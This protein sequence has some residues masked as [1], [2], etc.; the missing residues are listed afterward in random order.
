MI[1]ATV[2]HYR[3]IE[4][5]GGGGMGVVYKAEDTR[6]GRGVALK[7][8][9]E[10]F[11]PDPSA[12]ERFLREARAASAL[13]HPHICT[14]YDIG[15][16]EGRPYLVMELLEG[17]TLKQRME[18]KPLSID[19]ILDFG[20][21]IADALSAA[22]AKGIVHRDI[23]PANLFIT[24]GGQMKVL[25]FGLAKLNAEEGRAHSTTGRLSESPT[26][27]I[28]REHLTNPGSTIGTVAYMSTEQAR[29]LEVDARTDLFS[30]GV[31]LY[32]MATGRLP[33]DGPTK[34]V[35]FEALLGHAPVPPRQLNRA[36]PEDLERVILKA[37]DKDRETRYQSAS[38]MRADLKRLARDSDSSHSVTAAAP[39]SRSV[40]FKESWGTAAAAAGVLALAVGVWWWNAHRAP[41]LTEKDTVVLADFVN[42]TGDTM[43]DTILKQA[44]AVQL[45]QSPYVNILSEQRMRSALRFMGRSPDEHV[46]NAVAREVCEREGFKAML[47]GSISSLGSR[48]V[49]ALNAVSCSTGDALAREQVEAEDKEHILKAL[50]KAVSS[51]RAKLG[52]SLA[53][54]QK[55]DR[56]IEDATTSSLEAFKAFALGET[57]KSRGDDMAAIPL[58]QRAVELDPNFALA[59]GRLG[60]LHINH[61]DSER[62]RENF[63][64]AFALLNRVSERERLYITSNYYAL[65]TRETA[66]AIETLQLYKR[67]YP[68]DPTPANNLSREYME[69]GQ[70]ERAIE[71]YQETIRLD[72]KLA[73]GY[74]NLARAF[75]MVNRFD[76]AK[77][78]CERALAL[79][80]DTPPIHF[81]LLD[82][83]IAQN[84]AAG[85]AR[86]VELARGKPEEAFILAMLMLQ[87]EQT[88]QWRK[89][90]ELLRRANELARQ[91]KVVGPIGFLLAQFAVDRAGMGMCQHVRERTAEALA[92]NRDAAVVAAPALAQCGNTSQ[93]EALLSELQKRFPNDTITNFVVIPV[94]RAVMALKQKQPER[95]LEILKAAAPYERA[96]G[97]VIYLCGL[98]HLQLRASADAMADFQNLLDHRGA[99]YGWR[100]LARI[101]LARAATQAGDTAKSRQAYQDVLA[102]CKDAD[103]DVPLFQEVKREY[104]GLK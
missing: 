67:T 49:I 22:H 72:P 5:L 42:T 84:D 60:V 78:T 51:V 100:V 77:A 74:G 12:L 26:E 79:G 10:G 21:Q 53:S 39:V 1:G 27:V 101:G 83:A 30:F 69:V 93:A 59:Y 86:Q 15:E 3:I 80:L 8:L 38:D 34:A 19:E 96:H 17:Q 94:T 52:E 102:M 92:L 70:Y 7:F 18:S 81:V 33:F 24:A 44:L 98:A 95:A 56:P 11:H 35:V 25:D 28:D 82:M 61:G 46:T 55:M 50:G 99:N 6:L 57:Q 64:K 40:Q 9:P 71:G 104:A 31:V 58:Y 97:E 47:N 89:A 76:E 63:Q 43:F 90:E 41:A 73:I 48:Y 29:G 66:K 62:A 23:K 14:I 91:Y 45:E 85:I 65:G 54:I 32:E 16:Y 75:M 2:V 13:N 20:A 88:G 4:K 36:M 37:L 103:P 87:T 68:M